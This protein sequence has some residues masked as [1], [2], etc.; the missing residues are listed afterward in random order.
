MTN[1]K[2]N[3]QLPMFQALK[4]KGMEFWQYCA[5][6]VWADTRHKWIVRFIKTLNLSVRSFMNTDVQ[7][8]ACAM[9]YR[10]MLAF[11][12]AIALM[13]AIGRGF[14]LQSVLEDQLLRIFPAQ[15]VAITYVLDF[16]DSYLS[17]ASE[18]LFVGVGIVFLLWTLISLVSN[19]ECSFNAVWGVKTGR[20]FWRKI[21]DYTAML[22]ILPILMICASGMNLLLSSTLHSIFNFTFMTPVIK[23]T[24]EIGSW[25][26][27]WLFFTAVYMLIP[28][29]K[30]KFSNALIAGVFAGT[31]FL[32]LQWLFVSG[33]LY[34]S[35]YN[36]IYG[37][38]SF[39]PLLLLW[40]QLVW[41]ICLSGAVIC[42]SSQN[43]FRFS[44]DGEVARMSPIYRAKAHIAVVAIAVHRFET[45][46]RPVT[47]DEL[48]NKYDLPARLVSD[49]I[50]L[51]VKSGILAVTLIDAKNEIYGFQPAVSIDVLT[52][53]VVA[54]RIEQIGAK[55]FIPGF[56][57]NFPGINNLFN[58]M[59]VAVTDVAASTL[60]RNLKVND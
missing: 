21:T 5:E 18:G 10:T 29:T 6:G 22:L 48:I 31:G 20:S 15:Q 17:Q 51:L 24:L 47:T 33:Q 58:R 55:N 42:F 16:V 11:V 44:F 9:T 37:S 52:V 45:Q 1:P 28:N 57:D 35:R 36:A 25:V 38:F 4:D 56:D 3:H 14:G 27:T 60:I 8:Q 26:M 34:V 39:L 13:F 2:L 23:W 43:I 30:V 32:I 49:T 50:D 40:L 54:E 41:M 46:Q 59:T 53:G 7:S 19:V 12:P